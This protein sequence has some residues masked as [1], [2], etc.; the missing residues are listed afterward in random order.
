MY[1]VELMSSYHTENHTD[2]LGEFFVAS[3]SQDYPLEFEVVN[4]I[5][6]TAVTRNLIPDPNLGTWLVECDEATLN[7]IE[8]NPNYLVLSSEVID[9]GE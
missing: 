2:G 1:K 4:R 7:A 5:K 8:A 9:N 3:L 6:P